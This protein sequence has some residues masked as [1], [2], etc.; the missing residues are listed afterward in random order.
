MDRKKT[1]DRTETGLQKTGLS[2]A[3]HAVASSPRSWSLHPLGFWRTD[4]D[5]SEPVLTGPM[6]ITPNTIR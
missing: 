6:D 1:K 5:R 3:V 2:V 4:E